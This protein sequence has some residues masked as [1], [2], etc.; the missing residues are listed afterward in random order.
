[1]YYSAAEFQIVAACIH[2]VSERWEFVYK[3][4]DAMTPHAKCT[5]KLSSNV[6]INGSWTDDLAGLLATLS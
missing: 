6:L 2:P 3:R 1:R 4:S 5:G